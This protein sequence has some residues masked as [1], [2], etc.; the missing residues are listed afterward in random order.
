[1]QKYR[2]S[3]REI[4]KEAK[5]ENP[6]PDEATRKGKQGR[7]KRTKSRNFIE[8]LQNFEEDTWR[9]M[10]N[11]IVPFT[12]NLGENDIRMTKVQQKISGCFRSKEDAQFFFGSAV[13]FL[14][15]VNRV[16]HQ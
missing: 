14:L 8:R 9:F 4:L 3:Y 10:N 11:E 6:P 5:K 1:M 12:N 7:L 15:V 13:I 16:S 2:Q